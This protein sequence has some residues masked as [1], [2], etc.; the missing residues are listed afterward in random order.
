MN[1]HI[2]VMLVKVAH[3]SLHEKTGAG[4]DFLGWIDLPADYDKDEFS[5]VQKAADKIKAD[6]D[7]LL[8]IGIGGSYLGARAAVE[9]LNHSFY[10]ALSKEKRTTPQII[11]VGNNI[12]STY[13]KDV[14]DLLDGKGLFSQRDFQIRYNDRT[15]NRISDFP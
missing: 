4:S 1:L 10:N 13:I 2:Y 11:F 14:I 15:S 7:V 3:H 5:R 6:S 9:M 8:V 12:S